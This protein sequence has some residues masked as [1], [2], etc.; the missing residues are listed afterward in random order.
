MQTIKRIIA[1]LLLGSFSTISAQN[2]LDDGRNLMRALHSM[3]DT[4]KSQ[5]QRDTAAQEALLILYFYDE[6]TQITSP[7]QVLPDR[8][9]G[10]IKGNALLRD[11]VNTSCDSL[12]RILKPPT[13]WEHDWERLQTPNREKISTLLYGDAAR[14]PAEYLSVKRSMLESKLPPLQDEGAMQITSGKINKVPP[15]S[16]LSETEILEAMFEFILQRAKQE[17]V[18]SFFES[19]LDSLFFRW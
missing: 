9:L 17:V 10:H 3:R 19:L 16:V 5:A 1:L 12:F 6:P 15:T 18:E 2:L 14:T 11:L 4:S 7:A 13:T 8:V